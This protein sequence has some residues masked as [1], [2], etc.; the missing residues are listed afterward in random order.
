[1]PLVG[2]QGLDALPGDR[3]EQFRLPGL[4]GG[5][6]EQNQRGATVAGVIV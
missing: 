5:A 1:V 6:G 4:G 2:L 3:V